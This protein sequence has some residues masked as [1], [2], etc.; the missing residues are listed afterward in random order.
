MTAIV[1]VPEAI[2]WWLCGSEEVGYGA[3]DGGYGEKDYNYGNVDK[4]KQV[5][6]KIMVAFGE[7]MEMR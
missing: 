4:R 1:V 2:Q 6:V 7:E 5:V 3:G